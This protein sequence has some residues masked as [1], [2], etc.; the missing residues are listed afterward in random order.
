MT[1]QIA[2]FNHKG[3]VSKTTTTFNLGW[4]LANKGKRV[5]IVDCDPQCN[6]TG[7]VLELRGS[8]YD[9]N[10]GLQAIYESEEVRDIYRGLAPA[11]ESRPILLEP[12]VCEPVKGQ[13]NM[14]LLPGNIRFA[15]YE[16][17]LGMA[18]ELS[19]SLVS[20]QNL[21]GSLHY[22]FM[23]TAKKYE[24]DFIL[25]D[26]GLSLGPISRN[27]LM[28]SDYFIVPMFPDYFSMMAT[29][30]LASILSQWSAWAKQGRAL[31]ILRGA[32]YPFPDKIPK[33]LGTIIQNY[34]VGEGTKPLAAFKTWID[35]IGMAAE[36]KL[37]PVLKENDMLL[38]MELYQRVKWTQY[39]QISLFPDESLGRPLLQMPDFNS[40]IALSQKHRAP[41]FDLT[42][43]QLERD[44]IVLK[45]TKESIR[46]FWKLYSEG[47]DRIMMLIENA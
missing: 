20:L 32:T 44:G 36:R 35:A 30:S 17:V 37:I 41:I 43:A 15:E 45:Q 24:I 34:R 42:D 3:G 8:K 16:V 47:A 7:M 11:F 38:P 19:S 21:P 40:L 27:L 1:K 31:P 23:K 25:V 10:K 5:M 18:Q 12:V 13:P 26:M 39:D 2:L 9:I 22:L 4:M 14:Y 6:L 29:E 33:F 28:M 46:R